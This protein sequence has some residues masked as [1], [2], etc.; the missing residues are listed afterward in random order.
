M[1]LHSHT[2]AFCQAQVKPWAQASRHTESL[3]AVLA[4]CRKI[5]TLLSPAGIK[6]GSAG[7]GVGVVRIAGCRAGASSR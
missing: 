1:D 7:P 2:Q 3:Y 5:T 6:L 4:F